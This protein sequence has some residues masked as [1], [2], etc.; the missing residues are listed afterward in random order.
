MRNAPRHFLGD[1]MK[2]FDPLVDY[3]GEGGGE[4]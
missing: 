1:S 2:Q 4:R 3:M